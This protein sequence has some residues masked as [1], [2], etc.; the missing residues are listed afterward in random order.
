MRFLRRLP[1]RKARSAAEEDDADVEREIARRLWSNHR[2][3]P[4]TNRFHDRIRLVMYLLMLYVCFYVP[5]QVAFEIDY[6]VWQLAIDYVIDLLFIVDMFFMFRTTFYNSDQE[7]VLDKKEIAQ[8][9]MDTRFYIDLLANIPWELCTLGEGGYNT[10]LFKGLRMLRFLRIAR[11]WK[12]HHV[13]GEKRMSQL[14][15]V[16]ATLAWFLFSTHLIGCA[17]W[18]IGVAEYRKITQCGGE[19]WGVRHAPFSR[20]HFARILAQFRAPLLS[21]LG[22]LGARHEP[23]AALALGP[24]APGALDGEVRHD[25][26]LVRH[27]PLENRR[28]ALDI[29]D[30]TLARVVLPRA[31]HRVGEFERS[32]GAEAAV[33]PRVVGRALL[34][35]RGA[36][37][38]LVDRD[39]EVVE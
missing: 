12:L 20:G 6:P 27:D 25:A 34:S 31:H 9:Y 2:L 23:D 14:Q 32:A 13:P 1:G 39:L 30:D 10:T 37:D 18:G 11:I 28:P 38:V 3:L 29:I 36:H 8:S 4:P 16:R 7:L 35:A 24:A 19:P 17:W 33:L 15:R 21:D 26:A 22:H 5:M